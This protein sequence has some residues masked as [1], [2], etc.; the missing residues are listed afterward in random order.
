[1]NP[2]KNKIIFFILALVL[3]A[4]GLLQINIGSSGSILK[5]ISFFVLFLG[6]YILLSIIFNVKPFLVNANSVSAANRAKRRRLT[7]GLFSAYL[8]L[9]WVIYLKDGFTL[10]GKN[11]YILFL[12]IFAL[13][14]VV[15][16]IFK[17]KPF[18][19]TKEN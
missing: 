2:Q 9:Y 8:L 11:I 1:M 7:Y 15:A 18:T 3:I 17:L 6:I 5:Y 13:Y 4:F 16:A 12:L 14:I 10:T 19:N